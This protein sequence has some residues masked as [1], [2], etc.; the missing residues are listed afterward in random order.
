MK[1]WMTLIFVLALSSTLGCQK[2]PKGDPGLPGGGRIVATHNCSGTI[3]GLS[4][5]AAALNGLD[6][7]YD[8]VLTA[9]GD[10]YATARIIDEFSQVSSTNF[11]AAGQAG[12]TDAAVIVVGDYHS[13]ANGGWWVVSLNRSTLVTSIEY[14]DSSLGFQSPVFLTFSSSACSS[15][16]W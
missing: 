8:A 3:S 15:Q 1:N 6:V 2:G 13:T 10:I 4:S 16:Y 11:Y 12:A 5:G 14:T 7:E 9:G